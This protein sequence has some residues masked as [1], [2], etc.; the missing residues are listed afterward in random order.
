MTYRF[1]KIFLNA[2]FELDSM[3]KDQPDVAHAKPHLI[4]K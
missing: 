3:E 2:D 4:N 1:D